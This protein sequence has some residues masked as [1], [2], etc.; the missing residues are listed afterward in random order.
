MRFFLLRASFLAVVFTELT[1][2]MFPDPDNSPS[3]S[4]KLTS[5]A[6]ILPRSGSPL[7]PTNDLFIAPDSSTV[8][9]L[10][11]PSLN[12]LPTGLD[13]PD[14]TT[15]D[16]ALAETLESSGSLD[17]NCRVGD[18]KNS[19]GLHV[20]EAPG[21]TCEVPL[22]NEE[23]E[24][25]SGSVT[26][27]ETE[28]ETKSET[29]PETKPE[30]KSENSPKNEPGTKAGVEPEKESD[31]G[32]PWWTKVWEKFFSPT[33]DP[34]PKTFKATPNSRLFRETWEEDPRCSPPYRYRVCCLGPNL[35]G[36]LE[37]C[38]RRT[39]FYHPTATVQ[40]LLIKIFLQSLYL[41]C[42][43]QDTTPV[44]RMSNQ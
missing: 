1:A 10:Q 28:P 13:P 42:A 7:T 20:R 41:K 3:N 33:K 36:L 40:V 17:S 8:N 16:I 14:F 35:N 25:N 6:V 43:F 22:N 31:D 30:T 9:P 32:E 4:Q 18:T 24:P 23:T 38:K 39:C 44:V 21:T 2:L 11:Q 26:K 34:P 15:S 19:G 5:K 27:P 37:Y 29:K 12:D